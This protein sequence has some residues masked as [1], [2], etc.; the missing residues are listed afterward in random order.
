M[1]ERTANP[2]PEQVAMALNRLGVNVIPI[3]IFTPDDRD[4][5]LL[6]NEYANKTIQ[7]KP[8]NLQYIS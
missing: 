8:A 2:S 3:D 6:T 1:G 7:Q 5:L 4:V